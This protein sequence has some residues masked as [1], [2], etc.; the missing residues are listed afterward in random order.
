[1][2]S[3]LLP[4][5]PAI[6]NSICGRFKDLCST[7]HVDLNSTCE[8]SV[9]AIHARCESELQSSESLDG[10][11]LCPI[12]IAQMHKLPPS[13]IATATM[14][15]EDVVKQASTAWKNHESTASADLCLTIESQLYNLLSKQI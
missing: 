15:C 13:M 7:F 11:R 8:A 1:M 5:C 6:Q 10:S 9:N 14:Y 12:I 3:P 4:L 2:T